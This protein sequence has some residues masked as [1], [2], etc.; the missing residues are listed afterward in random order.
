MGDWAESSPLV[1]SRVIFINYV[2]SVDPRESSMTVMME[3]FA[4][5]NSI[6]ENL[7][8]CMRAL[9]YIWK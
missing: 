3:Q 9:N 7:N 2:D 8:S 5:N 6:S 1:R 4:E